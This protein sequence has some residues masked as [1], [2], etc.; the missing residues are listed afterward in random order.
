MSK[1]SKEG[2]LH[3]IS[4]VAHQ[5]VVMARYLDDKELVEV[6][7]KSIEMSKQVLSDFFDEKVSSKDNN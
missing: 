5:S 1:L 7:R 3:H 2:F 6:C 4:N